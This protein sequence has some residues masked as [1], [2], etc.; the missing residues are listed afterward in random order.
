MGRAKAL[1][2]IRRAVRQQNL[3]ERGFFA[4]HSQSHTARVPADTKRGLYKR[5]KRSMQPKE[6]P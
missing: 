1:K 4:A 2:A 3:Q 5:I 6:K